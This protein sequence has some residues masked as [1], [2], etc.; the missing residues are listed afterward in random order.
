MVRQAP[1]LIGGVKLFVVDEGHLAGDASSRGIHSEFLLNRLLNAFPRP[2][3]R[4]LFLSGVLPN[5]EDF[6]RWIGGDQSHLVMTNWRPS[7]LMVG[8]CKWNGQRVRLDF[9]HEGQTKFEQ[10]CYVPNFVRLRVCKGI[11]KGRGARSPFPRDGSDAF[12][13]AAIQC[14]LQATTLI[15]MPQAQHVESL[16]KQIVSALA[17]QR[18]LDLAEGLEN[19]WK[20]QETNAAWL[21]ARAAVMDELG[22]GVGSSQAP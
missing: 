12:A 5:P 3:C 20:H 7:R 21:K 9:T 11:I 17:V 16:G 10:N 22:S 18:Q 2:K 6:A 4:Y 13:A 19:R 15:F 14:G 8:T 1:D